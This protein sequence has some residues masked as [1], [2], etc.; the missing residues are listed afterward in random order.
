MISQLADHFS[1]QSDCGDARAHGYN[2]KATVI[3]LLFCGPSWAQG[4]ALGKC[5]VG[6]FSEGASLPRGL[7][8]SEGKKKGSR[9]AAFSYLKGSSLRTL[10]LLKNITDHVIN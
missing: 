2:E 5:P 7:D 3:R 9:K 6:I 10:C 1:E 4:R 8:P